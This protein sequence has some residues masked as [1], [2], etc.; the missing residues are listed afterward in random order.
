MVQV[1]WGSKPSD[2]VPIIGGKQFHYDSAYTSKEEAEKIANLWRRQGM[3]VRLQK[4]ALFGRKREWRG[5]K[6]Y[7]YVV[8]TSTERGKK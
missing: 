7:A 2:H 3:L 8:F 5:R 1:F 6:A 4:R